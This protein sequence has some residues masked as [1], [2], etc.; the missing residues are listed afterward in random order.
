VLVHN[1]SPPRSD[2]DAPN[3]CH[4]GGEDGHFYYCPI[5]HDRLLEHHFGH[6]SVEELVI[7]ASY[8][9]WD[10]VQLGVGRVV[11][12]PSE[13]VKF[14]VDHQAGYRIVGAM[15]ER[16]VVAL[17]RRLA[18]LEGVH[19]PPAVDLDRGWPDRTQEVI[20]GSS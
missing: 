13:R 3:A 20:R 1:G 4:C 19:L 2:R 15:A 18:V 8:L 6:E 5:E 10:V 14:W 16:P 12:E 7:E 11:W 9:G 17:L